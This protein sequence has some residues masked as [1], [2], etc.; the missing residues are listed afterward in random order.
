MT[1]RRGRALV[2]LVIALSLSA[3]AL[4]LTGAVFLVSLLIPFTFSFWVVFVT[5]LAVVLVRSTKIKF[6]RY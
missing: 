5:S 4:A 1:S 6:G 3:M 2:L